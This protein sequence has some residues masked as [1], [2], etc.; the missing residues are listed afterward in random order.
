MTPQRTDIFNKFLFLGGIDSSAR[1]FSGSA[2]DKEAL[3]AA[4]ADEIRQMTAVDFVGGSGIRFFDGSTDGKDWEV[5]FA[6]VVKG[7]L[8]RWVIDNYMYDEFVIKEAS[9]LIKNFLNYVIFS[10]VCPEHHD[11][12]IQARTICDIA[13]FEL[14]QVH[15]LALELPGKF[16]E[17]ASSLFSHR[18]VDDL[19]QEDSAKL[20]R[21][22]QLTAL[23]RSK[24]ASYKSESLENARDKIRK[25]DF[26]ALIK[27]TSVKEHD[28]KITAIHRPDKKDRGKAEAADT[29][30]EV[31]SAGILV[32]VP[33]IIAHGYGNMPRPEELDSKNLVKE[34]FILEDELLA[35]FEEGMTMRVTVC[36]LDVGLRIIHTVHDIR[37]SF[38]TFLAQ[39]LML[40]F[41]EP[42]I[43]DRPPPSVQNPDSDE[44]AFVAEMGLD[45]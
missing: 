43:N 15:E 14:R 17:A 20:F 36:E 38:D 9:A 30:C 32:V 18:M 31:N 41:K 16:N 12:I 19:D 8:S 11:N 25:L 2:T 29:D 23:I 35:K 45:D 34:E 4:D 44:D 39:S 28:Y 13:P 27:V 1:Q 22:F 3:A 10:D 40:T 24:V 7:F 42:R 26:P 5:D 37:P 21:Q 33:T 6:A